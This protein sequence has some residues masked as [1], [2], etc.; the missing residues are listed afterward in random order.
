MQNSLL[1][2]KVKARNAPYRN[3][4]GCLGSTR[5]SNTP[6]AEITS[7]SLGSFSETTSL[8][9]WKSNLPRLK[10]IRGAPTERFKQP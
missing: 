5:V 8:G 1:V 4:L 10:I 9:T 6:S 2:S 3:Q 7:A